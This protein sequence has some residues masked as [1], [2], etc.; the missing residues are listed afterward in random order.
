[1]ALNE[2]ILFCRLIKDLTNDELQTLL[3]NVVQQSPQLLVTSLFHYFSNSSNH[4]IV[5]KQINNKINKIIEQRDTKCT[6][7]PS[8]ESKRKPTAT[9]I[10]DQFTKVLIGNI[11]SFLDC[12]SYHRFM[13]TSRA[14]YLGCTAPN[15]LTTLSL[16]H[17]RSV[18]FDSKSFPFLR[19]LSINAQNRNIAANIPSFIHLKSLYLQVH[20]ECIDNLLA[21]R[22][23][24]FYTLKS[25]SIHVVDVNTEPLCIFTEL[26][27]LCPYL[28]KL[29]INNEGLRVTDITKFPPLPHLE[30]LAVSGDQDVDDLLRTYG[31]Q[32]RCLS[33]DEYCLLS[34]KLLFA[35]SIIDYDKLIELKLE[36]LFDVQ[37]ADI[38]DFLETRSKPLNLKKL[39]L[40]AVNRSARIKE[41]ISNVIPLCPMMDYLYVQSDYMM[42]CVLGGIQHGLDNL[43]KLESNYFKIRV[44]GGIIA[45]A[46]NSIT[47]LCLSVQI[48]RII[49]LLQAKNVDSFMFISRF[50]PG[51]RATSIPI[52]AFLIKQYITGRLHN[53]LMERLDDLLVISNMN[54]AICGYNEVLESDFL[55]PSGFYYRYN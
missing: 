11:G 1:M 35:P 46:F 30:I 29:Q 37:V 49:C 27:P 43:I 10:L 6:I 51:L 15:T 3:I 17:D 54:C 33:I 45:D 40:S 22:S 7:L 47:E 31:K 50:D 20:D 18:K 55:P 44:E 25:L 32:L 13:K 4:H 36:H 12:K 21:C 24:N 23:L 52:N 41:L 39:C 28:Q 48:E 2:A 53:V 8:K 5:N 42:D 26:L 19:E 34:R 38:C 9:I 16:F 14:C